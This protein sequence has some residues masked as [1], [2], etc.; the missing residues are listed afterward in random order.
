MSVKFGDIMGSE[1]CLYLNVY[2]P[3]VPSPRTSKKPVLLYIHGGGFMYGNGTLR[4]NDPDY[5]L[6][7]GI[8]VVTI[9]Y[10]VGVLGFLALDI[11][12]ATGNMGLKD[13]V[14]ALEWV[15]NNISDFGGDKNKV[16]I[17]GISA[18]AAAVDFLL[19]SPMAKGL[20]HGAILLSGS[21]LNHW[22]I[23]FKPMGLTR[24]LLK[25]FDYKG[26]LEDKYAIYEYFRTI[27][28]EELIP[29]SFEV[30]NKYVSDRFFFGFGPTIEKD[31]GN[32]DAFLTVNPYEL[33]KSGKF[34]T[35]PA[36]RGFCSKEGAVTFT[37]K[38]HILKE[39][40]ENQDFAKVWPCEFDSKVKDHYNTKFSSLYFTENGNETWEDF[41]GDID[42]IAGIWIAAKLSSRYAPVYLY[43]FSYDG[44]INFYK[45][46]MEYIP[47]TVPVIMNGA[48]HADD[49]TYV[50]KF[51]SDLYKNPN[52]H[53]ILVRKRM[54]KMFTDFV[55]T[56]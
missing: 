5:F 12:E 44:S 23:T 56:G 3:E 18:G 19:L 35:V 30:S 13:Q 32:G 37:T 2:T 54:V 4:N 9:N 26:S 28:V 20:F 33:L 14:K 48:M 47:N 27:S 46:M 38:V 6:E 24:Q 25:N 31:F 51:P 17:M 55:K 22:A 8:V 53:D 45:K 39:L 16:T 34:N 29:R 36:I 40:K 11:P 43:K 50:M 7:Y 21:T 15:K 10:R 42:F 49:F 41:F 52:E 1:D